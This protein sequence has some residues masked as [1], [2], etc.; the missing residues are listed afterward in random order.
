MH[1]HFFDNFLFLK[2]AFIAA[3]ACGVLLAAIIVLKEKANQHLND[4]GQ[5]PARLSAEC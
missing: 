1:R 4:S 3:P 2:F 5:P